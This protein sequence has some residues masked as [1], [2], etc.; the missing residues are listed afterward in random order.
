MCVCVCARQSD[1]AVVCVCPILPDSSALSLSSLLALIDKLSASQERERQRE[2]DHLLALPSSQGLP[3]VHCYMVTEKHTALISLSVSLSLS[4]HMLF[5]SLTLF[6][7]S[8]SLMQTVL[9]LLYH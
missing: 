2:K 6:F 8:S 9:L 7:Y 4:L 1:H 3:K 5:I